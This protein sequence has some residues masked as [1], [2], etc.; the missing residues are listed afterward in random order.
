MRQSPSQPR[1]NH[2]VSRTHLIKMAT[3]APT[4]IDLKLQFLSKQILSLSSPFSPS[5]SFVNSNS[6]AEENAL[7][8]KSVDEALYKLN[9]LLKKHNRLAYGPQA[10]RHV[11][12]QVDR[13]FWIAGERGMVG[14]GE[15][16]AERGVDYRESR[17]DV[18]FLAICR[19]TNCCTGR[20]N[21]IEQLPEEWSEEAE[22]KAPEQAAK[23][24]EL[25]QRL[26]E[27]NERRKQARERAGG[28]K[29][30]KGVL[31]LFAGEEAA[32]Q[33]N[34]VTKNGEVEEELER[35]RRLM[36]RVERGM[37]G[38]EEKGTGEE[39]DMDVDEEDIEEKKVLRL[40]TGA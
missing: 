17:L 12:E 7:R 10:K 8:Q 23:Y 38:L 30:F 25:Q 9:G 33:E 31:D 37:N 24:K 34:L 4:V 36:L 22:A 26:I 5:T 27:L 11:A 15:E 13:L 20:E 19:R 32:L 6:S 1:C 2:T 21:I 29:A 35:M 14:G 28:Y 40:L 18:V 16:W 39:D 3:S